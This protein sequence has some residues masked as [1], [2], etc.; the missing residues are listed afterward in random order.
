MAVLKD[1]LYKVPLEATSGDMAIE[2]SDFNFDSRQVAGGHLFIAVRGTQAD[3][4]QFID[5]AIEKGAVAV[6]VEELPAKLVADISYVQVKSSAEALGI[7][8]S[9]FFGNPSEK[10]ELVGVTG[11]NGKTTIV[12]LLYGLFKNLGYKPGMLSTVENRIDEEIISATHTT[13]DAKQLNRLLSLM[14]ARGCTHCF[15][16][17]SSHAIHQKR[18]KGL[19]FKGAIFSNITHDHLDY[20]KTFDEYIKAKKAFFDD[21][22]STAF[23]LVNADDK[24]GNVMVQNTKARKFTYGIKS[25]ADF[26]ARILSNTFQGLE[27]EINKKQTWFVL[28]GEFNAY[29]LLSVYGMAVLL[30]EDEETALTLLSSQR[31]AAGRFDQAP[32]HAG[33]VAIVDYAHTPDALENVLKTIQSIRTRNEKL[34]TVFGCGGNRDKAKRPL[35]GDIACRYSDK[36]IITSDNPRDEE[37]GVILQEIQAGVRPSDYKKTLVITDR[38]EA[39]KAA[40]SMAEKNDI[41]L[42]AGKGHENYQEIK[43]VK[44]DFDDKQ[45]LGEMISL[46][47]NDKTQKS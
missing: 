22:P 40:V 15:M 24:R 35:M 9:N 21:L 39:I 30:G 26:K 7:I 2:V 4:H 41:I 3:G 44:H 10:L 32:N 33:L 1:I 37:P 43:G 16:E 23:A 42:V 8:A 46:I 12:T 20:H 31:A 25:M 6:V 13:G 38:R 27:L 45:V 29:N 47:F 28:T 19:K 5:Q 14:V 34:I 18:I 11:T 17:V 36:V